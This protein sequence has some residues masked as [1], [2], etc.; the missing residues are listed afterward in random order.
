MP[1]SSL[2]SIFSSLAVLVPPFL[3]HTL[4]PSLLNPYS[5]FI[6]HPHAVGVGLSSPPPDSLHPSHL[7]SCGLKRGT[8]RE[9]ATC[10][11]I[12]TICN[13]EVLKERLLQAFPQHPLPRHRPSVPPPHDT[14]RQ[15]VDEV[16]TFYPET[17]KAFHRERG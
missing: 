13:N 6:L 10:A 3:L 5:V 2:S 16:A 4:S 9:M 15:L 1:T 17:A 11:V 7:L 8:L 12:E 14:R